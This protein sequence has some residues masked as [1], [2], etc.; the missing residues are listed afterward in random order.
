MKTLNYSGYWTGKIEGTNHGG[1]TLDLKQIDNNI[2][3]T[4]KFYEPD[5]GSYEYIIDGI[6]ADPLSL[7]LKPANQRG[8]NLGNAKVVG[9]IDTKGILNGRWK[10]DIGTEGIFTAKKTEAKKTTPDSPI[11][12]SVF[13]VHGHDE[14]VKSTL[15]LGFWSV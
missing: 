8:M 13:L 10:T 14:G 15:L 4:A 3:G 7:E 5:L 11:G 12:N 9:T 6:A 2:T 1:F